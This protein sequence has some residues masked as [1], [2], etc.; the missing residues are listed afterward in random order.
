MI[1]PN[2]LQAALGLA[3]AV[4]SA[5]G[6]AVGVIQQIKGLIGPGRGD[7]SPELQSLVNDLA[8][9]LTAANML[10]LQLSEAVNGLAN[11]LRRDDEFRREKAR[12]MLFET[13]PGDYVMK[14]RDD[15]LN[16]DPPHFACPVCLHESVI[17]VLRKGEEFLICHRCRG[18]FQI[19]DRKPIRRTSSQTNYF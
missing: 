12:Y 5:T 1:D 10:N 7:S 16:G 18:A 13:P 17:S 4:T 19:A 14:L 3:T 11:D 6:S 9:K 2:Q 15:C 8:Q